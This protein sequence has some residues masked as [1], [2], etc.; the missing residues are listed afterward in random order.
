VVAPDLNHVREVPAHPVPK[1]R[2]GRLPAF[3]GVLL[4]VAA[5]VIAIILIFGG[6]D[7]EST[8]GERSGTPT[9]AITPTGPTA[10]EANAPA[11]PAGTS[12]QRAERCEPIIGSGTANAGETYSVTSSATDGDPADCTE[13][14]SVLLG[15]LNG[16]GPTIGGWRCTTD[17]SAPTIASCTSVGGRAIQARG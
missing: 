1:E 16:G 2:R 11:A 10:G 5:A 12:G 9:V 15:A 4:L 8:T 14:R 6:G 13:A 17:P 3:L 7:D